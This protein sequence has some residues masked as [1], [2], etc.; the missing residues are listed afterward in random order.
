MT[1]LLQTSALPCRITAVAPVRLVPVIATLPAEPALGG[2]ELIVGEDRRGAGARAAP[3]G[4]QY[5]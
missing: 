4:W 2:T 1:R 5:R 3:R